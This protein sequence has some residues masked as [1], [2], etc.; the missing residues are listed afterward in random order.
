MSEQAAEVTEPE[1][2]EAEDEGYDHEAALDAA[3]GDEEVKAN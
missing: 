1:A 2:A 3:D